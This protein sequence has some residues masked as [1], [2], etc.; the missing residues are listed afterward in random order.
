MAFRI[1]RLHTELVES[2]LNI[3]GVTE[4]TSVVDVD[5]LS[6]SHPCGDKFVKVYWAV[7][8][9]ASQISAANAV[10]VAHINETI[11]DKLED[12]GIIHAKT[13]AAVILRLSTQWAGLPTLRKTQITNAIDKAA[14]KIINAL[15]RD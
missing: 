8:P 15:S 12:Q 10:V 11:E 3:V 1:K 14:A 6:T 9:N 13:L 7:A 4:P 2:G 5:E